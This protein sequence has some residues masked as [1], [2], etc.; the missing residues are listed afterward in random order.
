MNVD[1]D[2]LTEKE[3]FKMKLRGESIDL[4]TIYY[5]RIMGYYLERLR[6]VGAI[7]RD[8]MGLLR[9]TIDI[10]FY[11]ADRNRDIENNLLE[12]GKAITIHQDWGYWGYRAES[13][14]ETRRQNFMKSHR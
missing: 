4:G 14:A 6:D 8:E 12:E 10:V 7:R 11:A 9:P 5:P 1:F 13:F 2:T 3:V